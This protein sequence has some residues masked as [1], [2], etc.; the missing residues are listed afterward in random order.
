MRAAQLGMVL[1]LKGPTKKNVV[2]IVLY[3][4]VM[5]GVVV[6]DEDNLSF[7]TDLTSCLTFSVS[8]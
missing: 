2:S 3:F 5:C 4:T 1:G 8:S 6:D 7:I